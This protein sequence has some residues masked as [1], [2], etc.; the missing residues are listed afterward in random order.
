[1]TAALV[2]TAVLLMIAGLGLAWGGFLGSWRYGRGL[3]ERAYRI[4]RGFIRY[5][6]IAAVVG[7]AL[8]GV[9]ALVDSVA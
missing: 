4:L 2:A 5:G 6:L 1:M 8:L 9:T 3:G 7:A